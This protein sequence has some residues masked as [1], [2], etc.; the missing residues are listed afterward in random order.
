MNN[1][2]PKRTF[3]IDSLIENIAF[4]ATNID[5]VRKNQMETNCALAFCEVAVSIPPEW[6][7]PAERMIV[8]KVISE[9]FGDPHKFIDYLNKGTL[10]YYAKASQTIGTHGDLNAT[11]TRI[12][13]LHEKEFGITN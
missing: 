8:V 12:H 3:A 7:T 4:T 5:M 11:L 2:T 1:S 6:L 10:S 13:E 9:L